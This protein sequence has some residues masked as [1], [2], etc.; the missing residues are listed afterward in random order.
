MEFE[1][2][3]GKDAANRAKHG[4]GFDVVHQLD[5]ADA[6][7]VRDLRSDYGEPRYIVYARLG[8]RLHACVFTLR[9][10]RIRIRSLRQANKREERDYGG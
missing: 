1:W 8:L 2:D 10:G 9:K 4:L 6:R 5:W 7:P 3:D